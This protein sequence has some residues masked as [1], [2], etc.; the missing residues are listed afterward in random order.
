MLSEIVPVLLLFYERENIAEHVA[1]VKQ[2]VGERSS[3]A[4][5]R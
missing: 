5:Q 2:G 3:D 4:I 1:G